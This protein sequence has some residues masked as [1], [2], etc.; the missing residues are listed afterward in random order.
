MCTSAYCSAYSYATALEEGL[1]EPM[2]VTSTAPTHDVGAVAG[3]S[4]GADGDAG[5]RV[6]LDWPP[7]TLTS[8]R[9]WIGRQEGVMVNFAVADAEEEL[10]EFM[11]ELEESEVSCHHL[12]FLLRC[13]PAAR[14]GGCAA[15]G[16]RA[17]PYGIHSY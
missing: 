8:Q 2:R 12:R 3:G 13:L 4:A 5:A 6:A 9:K 14:D 1:D 17:G 11:Q 16:A 15:P 10:E 7:G